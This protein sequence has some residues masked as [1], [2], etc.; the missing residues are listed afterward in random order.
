MMFYARHKLYL[1]Q[2]NSSILTLLLKSRQLYCDPDTIA[3]LW[4]KGL[5]K[6]RNQK[7]FFPNILNLG[8][9][10]PYQSEYY[11]FIP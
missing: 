6:S 8:L 4:T 10:G 3:L 9:S 2:L 7:L 11:C 5:R 1:P